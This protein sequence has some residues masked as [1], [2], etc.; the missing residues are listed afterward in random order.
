MTEIE[1]TETVGFLDLSLRNVPQGYADSILL[2]A[3]VLRDAGQWDWNLQRR[4]DAD[5]KEILDAGDNDPDDF[6]QI[7][8]DDLDYWIAQADHYG[9]N[10]YTD[11]G[12]FWV[13][14]RR[15]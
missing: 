10:A 14:A 4:L 8:E 13:E 3:Q 7:A 9:F 5:T 12:T 1:E 6:Q 2:V 11:E 15:V